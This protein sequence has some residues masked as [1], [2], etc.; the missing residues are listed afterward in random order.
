MRE[1]K[2]HTPLTRDYL[3]LLKVGDFVYITGKILT[4]RDQAYKKLLNLLK[5]KEHPPFDFNYQV[6]YHCGPLAVKDGE[7]W[8]VISAGPTT[9]SR[10]ENLIVNFVDFLDCAIFIG[11]GELGIKF[12][13]KIRNKCAYLVFPG[14]AGSLAAKYVKKVRNIYWPELGMPEAVWELEVENFGPCLVCI[15]AHGSNL[16]EKLNADINKKYDKILTSRIGTL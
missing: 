12:T 16:F 14:G 1:H 13:E 7:Y 11:K 2:I 5:N 8:K 9:T 3:N 4:I 15:D 10:M 6:F